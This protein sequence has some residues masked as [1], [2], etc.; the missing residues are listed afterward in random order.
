[1][2]WTCLEIVA[3]ID[4]ALKNPQTLPPRLCAGPAWKYL[5]F[6]ILHETTHKHS[7]LA[8]ALALFEILAFIDFA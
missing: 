4:F 5:H 1:L 3:F 6:L 8:Y 7:H 2:P